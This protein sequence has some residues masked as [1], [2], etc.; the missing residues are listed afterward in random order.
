MEQVRANAP[1]PIFLVA[2]SISSGT[3]LDTDLPLDLVVGLGKV[4][5]KPTSNE[6]CETTLVFSA[7][8]VGSTSG[9]FVLPPISTNTRFRGMGF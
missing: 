1:L 7:V 9:S 5:A 3:R 8:G 2:K 4:T 6:V